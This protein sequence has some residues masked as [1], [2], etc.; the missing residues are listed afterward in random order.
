MDP[1]EWGDA[2]V[3]YPDWGG[4]AVLEGKMTGSEDIYDFT[5]IDR[6]EWQ[7]V[8]LD[9]GGGGN[10]MDTHIIA[11]RKSDDDTHLSERSHVEAADIRVHGLDPFELLRKLTKQL[12]I[13][14]RVRAVK[15]A[16]IMVTELLDEPPQED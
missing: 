13:R 7:I 10:L 16:T 6:D 8:G 14:M 9:L 1:Y 15:N 3:T 11:V 5:G 4:T 2:S 12:D